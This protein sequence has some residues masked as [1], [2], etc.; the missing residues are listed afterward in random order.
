MLT[1]LYIKDFA[2]IDELEVEFDAGLTILTGQTGAGKSII[3]G[4]LNMI[5]GERADTEVIRHGA[6]KAISEATLKVEKTPVLQTIFAE[7]DLEWQSPLVIR[8]EIRESGS[9]A[10][11]NDSPVPIHVLKSIGDVLVDLHGQHDHQLLLKEE[12]HRNFLDQFASIRPVLAAYQAE[13]LRTKAIHTKLN[14]LL[15]NDK[16]IREKLELYKFQFKELKEANLAEGEE[17]EILQEMRLLDNAEIL[18]QKATSIREIGTEGEINLM[19]LLAKIEDELEDLN[20][21]DSG[22]EQFLSEI[23]TAKISFNELFRFTESYQSA[24][25]F[26]PERLETLRQRH[27]ELKRLQKKYHLSLAEL[28]ELKNDLEAKLNQTENL[29]IEREKLEQ[30][31]KKACE[32]LS[33]KAQELREIR[34][35]VGADLAR[36]V[37]K[38][39]S[40]LGIGHSIFEVK[41]IPQIKNNGWIS[42]DSSSFEAGEFGSDLVAFYITTNKGIEPKPL[43]KTASG[44]EIS[45]VMLALK[46]IFAQEQSLPLMIFDE[47]DTGI[48][49]EVSEKVGRSMRKLSKKCQILCI[50]HQPQIASYADFHFKVHKSESETDTITKIIR[51]NAQEHIRE[52]AALMSGEQLTDASLESARLMINR[53]LNS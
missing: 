22:F 34:I 7:Y 38:E 44:G 48:S 4:A 5:L 23:Q 9:R 24:I 29:D 12:H 43:S 15:R 33:K 21:I 45:R 40:L 50:T 41:L 35:K 11:V 20:R 18:D 27:T 53:A 42:I 52:V 2:L 16:Q 17:E 28:I 47:I 1:T 46:S 36:Q 6:S 3:I 19:D 13:L 14:E 32:V 30:E 26:N 51:L 31:F 10:F 49:G 39:L 8:R 25:E 37:E